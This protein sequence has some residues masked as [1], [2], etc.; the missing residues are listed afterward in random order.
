M[1]KPSLWSPLVRVPAFAV[2]FLVGYR[3]SY[4]FPVLSTKSDLATVFNVFREIGAG[5]FRN[6]GHPE[7]AFALA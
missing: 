7:F 4:F 2:L 6:V 3:L 5:E 1:M